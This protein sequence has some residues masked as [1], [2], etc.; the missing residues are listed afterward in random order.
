MKNKLR[1]HDIRLIDGEFYYC[2]TGELTAET[3]RDRPCGH[4]G[5]YNT[6]EDHDGCLGAMPNVINACC[7]HGEIGEAYVQL[8]S[9][10]IFRGEEAL[11]LIE[12]LR[13]S[14]EQ[15]TEDM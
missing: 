9:K 4:C 1:G 3:W 6:P 11:N 14:D 7:G 12:K 10:E 5:L 13:T 2:D 15:L 8:T